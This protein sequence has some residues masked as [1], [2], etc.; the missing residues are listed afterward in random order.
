M[1]ILEVILEDNGKRV[2][3]VALKHLVGLK[4]EL[5]ISRTIVQ[6][7]IDKGEIL[8]NGKIGKV[9]HKVNAGDKIEIDLEKLEKSPE[10]VKSRSY[11]LVLNGV[12][13]GSGS[14]RIHNQQLQEKI[15]K[16]IGI[17]KQTTFTAGG[18]R[19]LFLFG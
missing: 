16:I 15:F 5:E 4:P 9:S 14:I 12:E 3:N 8:L 17:D 7:M 18:W 1:Y 2:D 6:D 11:D 19:R 13:L 10:K